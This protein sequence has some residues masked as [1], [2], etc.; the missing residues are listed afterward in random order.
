MVE[1]AERPAAPLPGLSVQLALLP[2]KVPRVEA[3]LCLAVCQWAVVLVA[4]SNFSAHHWQVPN[5]PQPCPFIE[6]VGIAAQTVLGVRVPALLLI[7]AITSVRT[8]PYLGTA[9]DS[10]GTEASHRVYVVNLHVAFFV[11][12]TYEQMTLI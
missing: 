12:V 9:D 2:A 8:F 10:V 6:L 3:Y 7:Y 4:I 11:V 1:C 5:F